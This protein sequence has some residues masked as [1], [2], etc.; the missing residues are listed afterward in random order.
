MNWGKG[1]ALALFAFAGM[2]A[3]FM[4]KAAQNPEPLVTEDYYA[5]EL[6]FQARI[7]ETARARALSSAV[8]INVR[9]RTIALTFPKEMDGQRITGS[10]HLLRPNAP[11]ADRTVPFTSVGSE[12]VVAGQDLLTGRYNVALHWTANGTD[13]F[14]EEKVFV[15]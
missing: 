1:I 14:T 12:V 4:V 13:Y 8:G 2:M 6:R 9:Q 7:D 11:G 15:P 3:W 10:I 5:E